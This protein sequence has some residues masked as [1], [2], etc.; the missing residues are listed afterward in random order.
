MLQLKQDDRPM[1]IYDE[2]GY[3]YIQNKVAVT[4]EWL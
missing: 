2:E 3:V 4:I 1:R